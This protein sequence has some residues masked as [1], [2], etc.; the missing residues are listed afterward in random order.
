MWWDCDRPDLYYQFY[1]E[2]YGG[3]LGT[4]IPFQFR[5]LLSV[6]PSFCDKHQEA[7]DR[8]HLILAVIRKV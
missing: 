3:R 4:L 2:L 7:L 6:L 1:P 5:L 8:L